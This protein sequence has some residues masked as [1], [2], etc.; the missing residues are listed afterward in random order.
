MITLLIFFS[1]SV[2]KVDNLWITLKSWGQKVV[3]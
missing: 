2:E 1:K 3:Y